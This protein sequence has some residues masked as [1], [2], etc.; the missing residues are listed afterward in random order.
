[1]GRERVLAG[2][3]SGARYV[4]HAHS[5]RRVLLQ[6]L[7]FVP[8]ATV[9]WALL[10]VLARQ[11]LN[12]GAQGFGMLLAALGAGGLVGTLVLPHVRRRVPTNTLV[13]DASLLYSLSVAVLALTPPMWMVLGVL[14]TS[15]GGVVGALS[16]L[17]ASAQLMLPE[18]VRARALSYFIAV[19]GGSQTV[20]QCSG[21]SRLPS[22]DSGSPF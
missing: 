2:L 10:P 21:K 18:W 17:N 20:G 8:V 9:L 22:S 12:L 1:M 7:F 11:Q 14:A 13:F 6:C 5:M 16:T 4:R 3:R 15:R 19:V